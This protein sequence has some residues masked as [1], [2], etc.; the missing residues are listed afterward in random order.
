MAAVMMVSSR[1]AWSRWS[2]ARR[3][4]R[5]HA[6]SFGR[7]PTRC[8]PRSWHRPGRRARA[9]P[10]SGAGAPPVAPLSEPGSTQPWVPMCRRISAVSR[11]SSAV[12]FLVMF[13]LED[14]ARG[15]KTCPP[16]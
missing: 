8:D 6:S 11:R 3:A 14:R 4:C 9:P 15:A 5:G 2:A 1:K 13:E 12:M 10:L 7:A 16:R